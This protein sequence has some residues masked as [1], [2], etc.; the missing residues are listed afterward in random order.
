LV[1][2]HFVLTAFLREFQDVIRNMVTRGEDPRP[3]PAHHSEVK[4]RFTDLITDG[5]GQQALLLKHLKPVLRQL[6]ANQMFGLQTYQ[7][8][9][10]DVFIESTLCCEVVSLFSSLFNT[11]WERELLDGFPVLLSL[12]D[13]VD[14]YRDSRSALT[15]QREMDNIKLWPQSGSSVALAR[16]FFQDL[17]ARE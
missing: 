17:F 10:V 9:A 3:T 4:E 1:D 5:A 14:A 11:H 2:Q 13:L 8:F 15:M 12:Q 16:K 6:I 7:L